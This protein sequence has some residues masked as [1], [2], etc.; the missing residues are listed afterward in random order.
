M[1]NLTPR[2]QHTPIRE[3]KE[4]KVGVFK[5]QRRAIPERVLKAIEQYKNPKAI[6]K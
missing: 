5:R 6:T 1:K 4:T 3:Q 2:E